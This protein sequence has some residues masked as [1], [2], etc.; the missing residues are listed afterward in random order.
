MNAPRATYR[1][2]FNRSFTFKDAFS[3]IPYLARLG[4]S[5]IY[6]SPV[7]M[8]KKG[9]MHGYDIIDPSQF[10]PEIGTEEEFNE[11]SGEAKRCGLTWLQ[12][13]VPNH[14][15]YNGD[16]KLLTDVL[17]K[18]TSS[19]YVNFF[20]IDW[21][22]PYES[23]KGKLLAPFLGTFYS[24]ALENG[25]IRLNYDRSGLTINYYELSFPLR[26]ESYSK[27]FTSELSSLKKKMGAEHPDFVKL[28][29]VLMRSRTCLRAKKAGSSI[30]ILTSSNGS[31]G[32]STAAMPIY[33]SLLTATSRR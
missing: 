22:H 2:Q 4:I 20:D 30:T 27:I 6:A 1:L 24:E 15:A 33:G 29:G 17:E 26:I 18:G 13:I 8:A 21:Q 7:F 3:I 31:F 23:I 32:N 9:S 14:M 25:E 10:N 11:L 28:M 16:N 19:Q 5:T 12:D